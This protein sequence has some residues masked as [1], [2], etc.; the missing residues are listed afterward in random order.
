M[1]KIEIE[2]NIKFIEELQKMSKEN[3]KIIRQ[4]SNQNKIMLA[5]IKKLEKEQYNNLE[6][7]IYFITEIPFGN[8][9]KIGMSKNP[10][11]RLKQLQTGNPNK[12]HLHHV[13]HIKI[14]N[15]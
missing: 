1:N 10:N 9:V 5:R 13:W 11:K 6:G 8:K 14:T 12:L 2:R 7:Y 3:Q 15:Y 4:I